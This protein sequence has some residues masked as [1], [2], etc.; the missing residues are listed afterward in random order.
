LTGKEDTKAAVIRPVRW[1][2]FQYRQ[3]SIV[4]FVNIDHVQRRW[5]GGS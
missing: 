5:R 3:Q 4:C 1:E 2:K